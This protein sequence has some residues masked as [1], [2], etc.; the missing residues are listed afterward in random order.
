[1][2]EHLR[3]TVIESQTIY[4]FCT[5]CN[6]ESGIIMDKWRLDPDFRV[7]LNLVSSRVECRDGSKQDLSWDA[8]CAACGKQA[9]K[10]RTLSLAASVTNQQ[11]QERPT[12]EDE[13][14]RSELEGR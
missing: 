6:R 1:M 10:F 11:W 13:V 3:V 9:G 12:T 8:R 7:P 2:I 14:R 5:S 4:D